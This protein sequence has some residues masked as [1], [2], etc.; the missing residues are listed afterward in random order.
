MIRALEPSSSNRTLLT[1]PRGIT[2][3]SSPKRLTVI[4]QTGLTA[5]L[6]LAGTIHTFVLNARSAAFDPNYAM[7]AAPES[8]GTFTYNQGTFSREYWACSA[9]LLPNFDA[10]L[11]GVMSRTCIFEM[12][13]RWAT[14]FVFLLSSVL[15]SLVYMDSRGGRHLMR[16]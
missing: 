3:V 10:D 1:K 14:L 13:S 5:A 12:G 4:I 9:R 7:S 6:A 15:F 8:P 2:Q 11:G 16:S